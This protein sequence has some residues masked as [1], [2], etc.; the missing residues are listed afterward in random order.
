MFITPTSNH[1]AIFL[2]DHGKIVMAIRVLFR[3]YDIKRAGSEGIGTV[4]G[5]SASLQ[6][7]AVENTR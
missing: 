2:Y 1:Y 3:R 5:G 4:T 7:A 6:I